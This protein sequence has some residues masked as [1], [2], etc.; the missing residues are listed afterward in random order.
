MR[1]TQGSNIDHKIRQR[2]ERA[3]HD[4]V[5]GACFQCLHTP[6]QRLDIVQSDLMRS[7]LNE[8]DLL[9]VGIDERKAALRIH[10]CQGQPRKPGAGPNISHSC[11]AQV[12][13]NGQAVEQVVRQHILAA[14][15]RSEVVGT[16]PALELIEQAQ[17]SAGLRLRQGETESS[18]VSDQFLHIHFARVYAR[19]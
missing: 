5:E 3:G 13:V 10:Y 8:A 19:I 11:A 15:D 2:G 6:M 9:A 18:G 12:R 14:A 16:I 17:E 4:R 7:M 1:T